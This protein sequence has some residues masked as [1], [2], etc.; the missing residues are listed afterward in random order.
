VIVWRAS[1]H[2]STGRLGRR[3]AVAGSVRPVRPISGLE[4]EHMHQEDIEG[5]GEK[6]VRDL[7]SMGVIRR[8]PARAVLVTEGDLSD[9]MYVVVEGRVRVHSTND[10]GRSVAYGD[11]GPG[12]CF[13]EL[14]MDGNPRAASV[15]TLQPTA[16]AVVA[17]RHV[18]EV[19]AASPEVGTFLMGMLIRKVRALTLRVKSLSLDDAYSRLVAFLADHVTLHDGVGVLEQPLTHQ[20]IADY[21][22]CSREMVTRLLGDLTTGGYIEMRDRRIVLRKRLPPAW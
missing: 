6:V 10:D 2:A 1:S 20:A 14:A 3:Q 7:A 5:L 19:I 16:C 12:E 8:Y 9:A 21:V 22:G 18:R 17:G 15:T 13:G 4:E 11:L